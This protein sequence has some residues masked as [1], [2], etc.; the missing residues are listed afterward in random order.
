[1]SS[2]KTDH[3]LIALSILVVV[4]IASRI[5]IRQPDEHVLIERECSLFYGPIGR[6]AVRI[7]Q[8]EMSV[9]HFLPTT[10]G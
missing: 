7:C 4:T 5:A 2:I 8:R 3:V 6:E 10:A 9:R 1:M